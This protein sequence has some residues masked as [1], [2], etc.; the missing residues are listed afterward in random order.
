MLVASAT[1]MLASPVFAGPYTM[2]LTGVGDGATEAGVYVSPYVGTISQGGKQIYSGYFI[3]DDFHTE[4]WVGQTWSATAT[5]AG[6]LNGTEKFA[7]ESYTLG[8]NTYNTQQMYDAAGWLVN[9]LLKPGNVHNHAA[10]GDISFAIWD[11]M[12]G[13][14]ANGAV[15]TDI[16]DAFNAVVNDGY[17][18]GNI[19]V[20]SPD[21]LN[22]SQEF[23]VPV[24]VPEPTG[25][26]LFAVGLAGIGLRLK[27]R[28]A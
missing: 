4:S 15:L 28:S 26:A 19:E 7:G 12:D 24:S 6:S 13:T 10:Q 21:P 8:G 27:K 25:L 3:C 20:F 16:E 17:V 14:A 1:L 23:L 9:D 11:I 22:A 5:N 2:K 18:A